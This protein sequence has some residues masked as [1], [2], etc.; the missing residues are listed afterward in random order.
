MIVT[1]PY[2]A[3]VYVVVELLHSLQVSVYRH[4]NSSPLDEI[5]W[6]F[7]SQNF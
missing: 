3:A 4:K 5:N 1:D 7:L 6:L 2:M